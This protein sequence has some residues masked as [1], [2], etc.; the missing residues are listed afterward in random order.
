MN[1]KAIKIL[2]LEDDQI[3]NDS[4][5]QLLQGQGY[6][7]KQCFEGEQGLVLAC[8]REYNLIL[9]DVML[10]EID[11][12]ELLTRLREHDQVPV[13][14]LSA[15]GAEEE[16]IK[17]LRKGADDYL[18]KPFNSQELLLRI[19]ALLRRCSPDVEMRLPQIQ[20]LGSLVIDREAQQVKIDSQELELTPIEFKL[21]RTLMSS[22][23]EVLSKAFLYQSVL[24]RSFS[25]Y[26][27]SLDMHLSRIRRK[28]YNAGWDETR[29]QT[30]HGKGYLLS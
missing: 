26:D 18:S 1:T 29:L 27:R 28:L 24:N 6:Q 12:F 7:V 14:I 10:P 22:P 20:S 15:K 30:V 25:A 4:L 3:L 11:G 16:R 8:S 5:A 23:G 9:L 2:I 17:G 19:E 13:I 21:L